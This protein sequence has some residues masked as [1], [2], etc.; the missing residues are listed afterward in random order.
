MPQAPGASP[1]ASPSD[2]VIE[3]SEKMNQLM[4]IMDGSQVVDDVDREN[5]VKVQQAFQAFIKGLESSEPQGKPPQAQPQPIAGSVP[6][7][8]GAAQSAV[9]M[10]PQGMRQ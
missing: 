2:L 10:G 7:E 3:I 4:G 1:G 5:A 9:P 6:Q 8:A